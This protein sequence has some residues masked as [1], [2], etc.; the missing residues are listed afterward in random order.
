MYSY[1]ST[2]GTRCEICCCCCCRDRGSLSLVATGR[3]EDEFSL[4]A[5]KGFDVGSSAVVDKQISQRL[6]KESTESKTII[7]FLTRVNNL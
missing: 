6:W 1:G 3:G 7:D 5:M 4:S 2:A